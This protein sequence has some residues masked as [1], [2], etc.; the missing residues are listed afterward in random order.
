MRELPPATITEAVARLC[1]EANI[2]LPT[3][4][5]CALAAAG[6]REEAPLGRQIL[7]ELV[8]NAKAAAES[9]D[10][11]CQDTGVAVVFV[12]LGQDLHI[13]GDLT[14]AINAGVRRGY[15]EHH[16]R[17]SVV[18][19]PLRRR[20][21]GD[22]TPA[23]I[24]VRI[25]PGDRLTLTVA[26][27]GAGSENQSAVGLLKPADGR[28]GV[29]AFVT[30]VVSRAGARACPPLVVGVGLGGTME[31]AALLAKRALLR[32]VDEASDDPDT[33]AL[34]RE[35]LA[36]INDSGIGPQGFGGRTTALAVACETAPCHIASLPVA[37]NLNCHVA[38]HASVTL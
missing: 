8:Q 6:E 14:D 17:A 27:K 21:T 1:G 35:L 23:V 31:Q 34:E 20:N 38:R 7:A 4:V 10:P 29:V 26:P 36:R 25:V 18:E 30:G 32:P 24:H 11:I 15:R 16:L 33:A 19:H 3:D 37:V 5:T 13:S 22:N 28:D 2:S 9:G 12:D